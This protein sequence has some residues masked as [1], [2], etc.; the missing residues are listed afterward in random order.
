MKESDRVGERFSSK[1]GGEFVIIKYESS[2]KVTIMF[3]NGYIATTT[4]SKCKSG[5]I[6]NPLSP[7]IYGVGFIGVGV[8]P[9]SLG[10]KPTKEYILWNDMLKRCYNAKNTSSP[11]VC[12]EWHNFQNFCEDLPKIEGYDL[13]KS[14][15]KQREYHLDKDIKQKG[16][17]KKV[18][19]KDT[20]V[21]TTCKENVKESLQRR[22]ENVDEFNCF[23]AVNDK[24]TLLFKNP[25]E[26][27][28]CGFTSNFY[29]AV[30]GSRKTYRGYKWFRITK[31]E[32]LN[33]KGEDD[34]GKING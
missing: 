12:E 3:D 21:F 30:N 15:T 26:V 22:W 9:V 19:S 34:N 1:H 24:E 11:L 25:Q 5:G 33:N 28:G 27:Y 8:H 31:E 7:R 20:C 32:Y 2:T 23:K 16:K 29:P 18:Y 13:W 17:T 6:K 10:G 14:S 4:Y